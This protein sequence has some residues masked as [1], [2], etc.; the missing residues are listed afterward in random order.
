MEL[1]VEV[2]KLAVAMT[3]LV[4]A[5]TEALHSKVQGNKKS[6]K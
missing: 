2:I 3:S 4:K 1:A 6:Q 5:V